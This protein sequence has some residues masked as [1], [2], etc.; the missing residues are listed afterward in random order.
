MALQGSLKVLEQDLKGAEEVFK[1]MVELYPEDPAVYVRR[2]VFYGA[3]GRLPDAEKNLRKA[4][5]L[6]ADQRDAQGVLTG[7][8]MQQKRYD[9]ALRL[10]ATQRQRLEKQPA[11]LAFVE[12][13]EG[14][15]Y[16]ARGEGGKAL[17]HFEKAI[18]LDPNILG[19]YEAMAQIHFQEKRIEQAR[20]QYESIVAKNPRHVA[21]YMAL[22]T[23]YDQLG[24]WK[25]AEEAYRKA[26]SID[27]EFAPAANNLAWTLIEGG[28]NIDEA[29]G[30]AQSAKQKMPKNAAVMDTLGWI[31]YLKG[32]T[33]SAVAELQDAVQVEGNNALIHYHLGVAYHKNNQ[34]DRAKESLE[35]ALALSQVFK[36]AEK[37]RNLLKEIKA[38]G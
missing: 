11:A 28:G 31:Y 9:E 37:A 13:L 6:N 17:Q 16:S 10:C 25:K 22:G 23:I 24:D 29:L 1:K 33:L 5:E 20:K 3:G 27:K 38:K 14:R 8:Y 15:I 36:D 4:L 34:L 35:K 7:L 32:S 26:L 30:Y 19:A 18:E 21:G 12:Y 2:G